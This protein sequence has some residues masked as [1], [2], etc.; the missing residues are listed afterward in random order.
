[1]TR[2][3]ILI[4]GGNGQD[5]TILANK[6]CKQNKLDI[7]SVFSKKVCRPAFANEKQVVVD[8]FSPALLIQLLERWRPESIYFLAGMTNTNLNCDVEVYA[9][10][11]VGPIEQ[12]LSWIKNQDEVCRLFH[13]GSVEM[14]GDRS[15]E[16]LDTTD[17]K[18]Q[19]PYGRSKAM[20]HELVQGAIDEGLFV[21]NSINSNHESILRR[22]NF[23]FGKILGA[24]REANQGHTQNIDLFGKE[25]L[26]DWGYAGEFAD[27]FC[28]LM[29]SDKPGTFLIATGINYSIADM[30]SFLCQASGKENL[31]QFNFKP[32]E[33]A[34]EVQQR[35]FKPDAL[36]SRGL[37]PKVH[38]Q[39]LAENLVQDLTR[40][41]YS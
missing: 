32:S 8:Y 33:R 26:K 5:A 4:F 41:T 18:P 7:V 40:E 3:T 12:I 2:R 24:I 22:E 39:K 19:S 29:D 1:M 20:A 10:H 16:I 17:A 37:E 15:G 35:H 30:V 13:A 34:F 28:R 25:I 21:V 27:I 23:L 36:L 11:N 38:G 14:F 6:L 9:Y 31:L